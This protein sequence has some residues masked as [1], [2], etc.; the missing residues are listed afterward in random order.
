MIADRGRKENKVETPDIVGMTPLSTLGSVMRG[1][2][3]DRRDR[4]GRK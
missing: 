3:N 2:L 4:K 1:D